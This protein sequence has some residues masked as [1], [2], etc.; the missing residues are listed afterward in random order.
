MFLTF[1]L[2]GSRRNLAEAW[3]WYNEKIGKGKCAIVDTYWQTVGNTGV[4]Q[5]EADILLC[6]R[7]PEASC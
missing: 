7:N 1:W 5:P 4:G 3:L 6:S 2:T